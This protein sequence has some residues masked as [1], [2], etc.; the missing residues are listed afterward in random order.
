[1]STF[2][3]AESGHRGTQSG[4]PDSSDH[5]PNWR[6]TTALAFNSIAWLMLARLFGLGG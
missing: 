4:R 6:L 3:F 1:M 2:A 5:Y